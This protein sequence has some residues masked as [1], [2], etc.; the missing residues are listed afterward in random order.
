MSRFEKGLMD[1]NANHWHSLENREVARQLDVDPHQGLDAASVIQRRALHGL[2]EIQVARRH[3]LW[4]MLL[5]QFRDFMILVLLVA[6]LISGLVGAPLDAAAIMFIVLMNAVIGVIQEYRAERAVQALREMA[7][8]EARVRREGRIIR[9]P[10]TELVPGDV[11]L[12]SAGDVVPADLRL[13]QVADLKLDESALTGESTVVAK[14]NEQLFEPE[15]PLADRLNMGF[16]GTQVASGRG[17]GMVVATGMATELGGIAQLL[18]QAEEVKTPLQKRLAQLGRRLALVVLGISAL[19]FAAGL[20]RGEP[21]LLMFLTAISLAVAAIPEALPAVVSLTLAL[22]AHKMSRHKALIRT[23]P[24]VETL[25][26]VTY[27]CSDKTG[28]LTKNEMT[29]DLFVVDGQRISQIPEN[30]EQTVWQLMGQALAL[31][32]DV[33]IQ[34]GESISGEPTELALYRV[35]EQAGFNKP[36]L[37]QQF[38]RLAEI[39]FDATRKCMTTLHPCDSGHPGDGGAIAFIKGAPEK[40]LAQCGR[41]L[42]QAGKADLE[43]ESP[44]Q[45]ASQ[46]AAEGYRVMAL[47]YRRFEQVP[48]VIDAVEVESDLTLLGLVALIDPPREEVPQAVIDCQSA[49]ITPVLITGDHPGTARAIALRLGIATQ[50]DEMMTGS[51]LA[52]IS[53]QDFA[54]RVCSIRVYARVTPEQKIR[55][56]EALQAQGEFVAMTGDGVNDAP[57]LKRADIGVAMGKKGTEVAREASDMVLLD[58]NFSTIV[59]AVREGRRIYDNIRKFVRYTMTS[60][61]G[62]IWTLLLAPFLGLPIP[63]LPIH[64][65]WINLV[66]DGLPGLALAVEPAEKGVMERPPRPPRENIFAQGM[67]QHILWVGLLIGGVSLLAQAWAITYAPTHWQ[68]MVFTVLTLSQLANVMAIRSETESLFKIGL[69]SNRP[70]FVAVVVTVALQLAVIYLPALNAIFKT[71]PLAMYELL[72]CFS[73]AT[74]VFVAVEIEKWVIR[75]GWIYSAQHP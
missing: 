10:A 7:A 44:L 17:E 9:L 28:T 61:S 50:A 21:L 45:Q 75:K 33:L 52:Q 29:V 74:V 8:P 12:L 39:P 15:Q 69:F 2:N 42:Q 43:T 6:A 26:S 46:L 38:P 66:T 68:T 30:S 58:D 37:E 40:V 72:I 51:E 53:Q 71:E 59:I 16:K 1:N 27:I 62:E 31:N 65:L 20:L 70:L 67:W 32:S 47:A 64:I 13:S 19:I 57:A 60:N 11:V 55:I 18:Q 4:R 73:L 41:Q 14:Q 24:A 3:P 35:A 23:L 56:V 48:E 49:G 25:G 34:P 5:S 22:G 36:T 54:A 63:L